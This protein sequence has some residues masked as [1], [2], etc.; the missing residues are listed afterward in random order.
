[1]RKFGVYSGVLLGVVLACSPFLRAQS[2]PNKDSSAKDQAASGLVLLDGWGRP[3]KSVLKPGEKPGRA[4]RHDISGT[5][6]PSAA[7]VMESCPGA[8]AICPRTATPAIT[9]RI[10]NSAG[11]HSIL[12]SRWKVTKEFWNR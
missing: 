4:P 11:R 7:R 8:H 2:A 12:T 9:R 5:W 3:V 1:M 6:E 10:P